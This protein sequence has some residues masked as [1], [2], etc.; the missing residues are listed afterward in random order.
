LATHGQA[1]Q[2]FVGALSQQDA[3]RHEDENPAEKDHNQ[4]QDQQEQ[5]EL[6]VLRL[7]LQPDHKN[8]HAYDCNEEQELDVVAEA[9]ATL[10]R[11]KGIAEG[12]VEVEAQEQLYS[13]VDQRKSV[14]LRCE[15]DD[16][17]LEALIILI[18]IDLVAVH[19][20]GVEEE[21]KYLGRTHNHS[22]E[23]H[24]NRRFG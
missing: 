3:Q 23:S 10:A 21:N 15:Q 12:Q 5:V 17:G 6:L 11:E 4:L 24:I 2:L 18:E 14:D 8:V 16:Y 22:H 9:T 20:E 13:Q 19:R 7:A 1:A